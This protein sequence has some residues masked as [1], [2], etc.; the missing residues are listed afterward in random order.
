MGIISERAGKHS[1]VSWHPIPS[2]G[3]ILLS[4]LA[5][6]FI[7]VIAVPMLAIPLV[8]EFTG[9]PPQSVSAASVAAVP[10][11]AGLIAW[12]LLWVLRRFLMAGLTVWRAI[13]V[14]VLVLSLSGPLV[15]GTTAT[16]KTTLCLMHLA[17]AGVLIAGLPRAGRRTAGQGAV[18]Q[19]NA[20]QKRPTRT[21]A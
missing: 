5:S 13:A 1:G 4:A 15:G 16:V 2:L 14:A 3:W 18:A 12:V 10:V 11:G 20:V 19:G 21:G 6:L 7:W 9:A 17:V 8:V